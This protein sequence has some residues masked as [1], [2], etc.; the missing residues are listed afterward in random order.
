MEIWLG[1]NGPPFLQPWS[2]AKWFFRFVPMKRHGWQVI[3]S[4]WLETSSHLLA[5]DT[6]HQFLLCQ[7]TGLRA[8]VGQCQSIS[9]D[10]LEVWCV[11][12][13]AL[14]P[15]IYW[16]QNKVSVIRVFVTSFFDSMCVII[17]N[18]LFVGVVLLHLSL[19]R[20]GPDPLCYYSLFILFLYYYFLY[21]RP[22]IQSLLHYTLQNKASQ[23]ASW[24]IE[25][26]WRRGKEIASD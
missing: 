7:E 19:W 25:D 10:Y 26:C 8:L 23:D 14:V 22:T 18:V 9:C 20:L 21:I 5:A 1:G 2:C 6:R 3:G 16:S 11:P 24:K 4:W 13:A 15:C 17:S 12:S